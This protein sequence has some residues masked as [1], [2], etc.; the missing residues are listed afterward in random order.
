[1]KAKLDTQAEDYSRKFNEASAEEI[2]SFFLHKYKGKIVQAASMGAEDQVLTHMIC[3]IDKSI[4]IITLDT[5]RLFQETY[6]LIAE[7]N[8]HFSINI[9]IYFP[10]NIKVEEMI[11]EKGINLFYE[12]VENRKLCCGIRKNEPLN[13]A[14]Q[15][16]D[17]W[18]CG[19]RKDQT[20]AR[21]YNKVV[22]WDDQ[23][24]LL[25]INPL[26]NWTEKQVWNYIR[27]HNIPYNVLHDRGF[28]SVGCQ[29]CTR[30]ILPGEDSRSGRWWWEK[31]DDKEC[32]LHNQE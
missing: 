31:E 22:E 19:L 9:E 8:I 2:L 14:L 28:P 15:G 7:T 12:S 24:G 3:A 26:I 32:G 23:H 20:V 10:D 27:E 16:M 11:K 1:M 17:V 6:D 18:I 30:A 5:R 4:R 25:K 29:P 13:R 21:F